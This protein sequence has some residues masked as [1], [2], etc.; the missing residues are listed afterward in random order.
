MANRI[1][2]MALS[3]MTILLSFEDDPNRRN[4]IKS[5]VNE[6]KKSNSDVYS[7]MKKSLKIKILIYSDYHLINILYKVIKKKFS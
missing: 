2:E 6:F 1:A 5:F 7:I 4:K 3:H